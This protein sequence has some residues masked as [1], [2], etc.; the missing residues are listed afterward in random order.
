M[1]ASQ[2]ALSFRKMLT[3]ITVISLLGIC[4]ASA[5]FAADTINLSVKMV[6]GLTAADQAAVIARNGG[7]E[8]S[9]VAPLRLHVVSVPTAGLPLILSDYK[10]D[11]QVESVE[12][13]KARK[14]EGLPNDQHVGV[15]WSLSKIGWPDVYGKVSPKGTAMVALLDT[16]VDATHPDLKGN[17]IA[18]TSILDG[19]NGLKDSS[20]HGTQMAGIVAAVTGNSKGIAGIAYKNVKIMP[21]TVLDATGVGQDSDIIAGVVWAADHGAN[22]ILMGFSNPDFSQHLQDAIDYAWA[23]GAVLVAA[24]GNGGADTPTFPAGDRGVIGVSATDPN[25]VLAGFS[26]FGQDV[27]LA[28]PGS[29]IYTTDLNKNY[30][31][32]SGTSPS[33]AVVAGVAAFMKAVDPTLTNGVI[34]GRLAAGADAA[35]TTADP[36]YKQKYGYGRVSMAKALSST[37]TTP[38]EPVGAAKADTGSVGPY[39]AAAIAASQA[40]SSIYT[41]TTAYPATVA[42]TVNA[43]SNRLLVVAVSSS[44]DTAGT[45][46]LTATYGGQTSTGSYIAG[47]TTQ[48]HVYIIYWNNAKLT[49]ATNPNIVFTWTGTPTASIQN[50]Y[51]A[52]Y[53]G[54]DQTTPISSSQVGTGTTSV[55]LP[56]NLTI[57]TGGYGVEVVNMSR[58]GNNTYRTISTPATNWTSTL[59]PNSANDGTV[60]TSSYILTDTTAGTTTANHSISSG[61]ASIYSMAAISIAPVAVVVPTVTTP[62]AASISPTGATLGGNITSNGGAT[63]TAR[64][65]CYAITAT[66]R[67]NCLAEGGTAVGVFTQA[68]TGFTAGQAYFYAAYATNS[69]GTGYSV[70]GTFTADST[71]AVTAP[72]STT[73]PATGTLTASGG[74]SGGTVSF[75]YVSGGCSLS[76]ANNTTLT[77]TNA[78]SSPCVVTAT[79]AA[80]GSYL[81]Q[82]SANFNAALVRAAASASITSTN[83][84][85]Y[86]G[87]PQT[88]TVTCAGGGAAGNILYDSSATA[89]T[90]VGTYAVTADCSVSSNYAAGTNV[91]AGDFVI[92][93][94]TPTASITNSP[95]IYNA[96]VQ[97]ATV[98]CLGGGS[99]TL[100]SGGTGTTVGSYPATVNCA[101]STNYAAASGLS[102]GNFVIAKATATVD[103]SNLIQTYTG[104]PLTPTAVTTPLGLTVDWTGAPQTNVGS[105]PVTATINNA[106]YQGFQTG[107]FNIN[108]AL[109]SVTVSVPTGLTFTVDSDPP[110]TTTHTFTWIANSS[111]TISTTAVQLESGG[112]HYAFASWSDGKA[113]SHAITA[114]ATG[115]ATYTANFNT[116]YLLTTSAGTG[117]TVIPAVGGWYNA[118]SNA[119]ISATTTTG[120]AFTSWSLTSGAGPI[121]NTAST[122]T[123]VTMN[124]PNT[125]V[126]NTKAIS[127]T[128]SATLT[129]KR[130]T[131]G[132][133]RIWTITL[134]NT[135]SEAATASVLDQ[136]TIS[137]SG[138]C[139]PVVTSS[140]PVAVGSIPFGGSLSGEVTINFAGCAKLQKFNASVGYSATNVT[141]A[142]V[143][144]FTGVTQ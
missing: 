131:F 78:S 126:A 45:K 102:A 118:G 24:T 43:G 23:K 28:A 66:P 110:Y 136:L 26:N 48:A 81:A 87:S 77:I 85:T 52:V 99:A 72:I 11:P 47:G 2:Y 16:G 7:V 21:V 112:S 6:A 54:V 109:V 15:Q 40:W 42:F 74:L 144:S 56:A 101:A 29:D 37:V 32:I 137:S 25:D 14:A 49:A 129:G 3:G 123:T 19:S 128:L 96:S 35:G 68:R 83:P 124:A 114:P 4:L 18:G 142:G 58:T 94:A 103:L 84:V 57:G 141:P 135:G 76:G 33:S 93:A 139:K 106:N 44:H 98:A 138:S 51:A 113:I 105:Y 90:N 120:Y 122:A 88:A 80:N 13:I 82:T 134:T 67:A 100:A 89:P 91:A 5:A 55:A 75:N 22:V 34:L 61:S 70:D 119:S 9:V 117:G 92:S 65:T 104:S 41:S 12:V 111:H 73:Y 60:Y 38:I 69:A 10:K 133:S 125:V 97:T 31:Y 8:K 27:F 46:T 115:S 30:T 108:P 79:R 107:T 143:S 62:T 50:V 20:G 63:L 86:N 36:D 1:T 140:F 127:T 132:G 17:V 95:V 39:A 130:G 121:A 116:Q 59:G 71:L 64:G 53:T